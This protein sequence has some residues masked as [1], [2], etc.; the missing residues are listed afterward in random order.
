LPEARLDDS[1]HKPKKIK[2]T[3]LE[4]AQKIKDKEDQKEREKAR[5]AE[6]KEKKA[7]EKQIAQDVAA[8]NRARTD[9][10]TSTPEMIVDLHTS[11]GETASGEPIRT[12]LSNIGVDISSHTGT[13]PNL[14]KWRRKVQSRFNEELDQWEPAPRVIEEEKHVMCLLSATEFV[15]KACADVTQSDAQDLDAHVMK[16]KSCYPD[17]APIYLV[18]GLAAWMKKNKSTRNKAYQAAVINQSNPSA[19]AATASATQGRP[20]KRKKKPTPE[21]VDEDMIEDA[22]LRLQVV[23]KCLI[24]HTTAAVQ[25]AE[26]VATFTQH[27]STIPYR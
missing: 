14:I 23:H 22:L 15:S 17:C 11:I 13:I 20:S 9:K 25:T 3:E 24:H 6:E 4:R 10:K 1:R 26:W 5:K 7:R 18:E 8:V 19:D 12:F 27:I 16:I 2:L 21:Y